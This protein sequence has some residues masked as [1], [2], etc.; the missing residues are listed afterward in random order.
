MSEDTSQPTAE[1][2]YYAVEQYLPNLPEALQAPARSLLARASAGEKMDNALLALISEDAQAR[3]W[4]RQALFGGETARLMGDYAPL[5]GSPLSVP[6]N[7]LWIC[8]QCGFEWRVVRAGRPLPSCP[9]DGSAL[10]RV[11]KQPKARR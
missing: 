5:P 7:S 2:I 6:A 11:E 1:E 9:R 8:P 10:T 3:T 4:L